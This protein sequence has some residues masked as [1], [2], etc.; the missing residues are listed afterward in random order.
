MKMLG[1]VIVA[2]FGTLS[3]ACLA[4]EPVNQGKKD[5]GRIFE[6]RTYYAAPGKM[7]ALHERFRNH[8]NKLF[9]KHGM[10]IIGFWAPLDGNEAERK[11]VYMLAFPSKEAADKSWAGFRN[12]PQWKEAREASEVNGKLVDRVE[13]VFLGATDYSPIK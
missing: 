1:I 5:G 6:L 12:D 8:T 11:L 4:A 10:T 2:A 13:S 9:V 3:L 7:K